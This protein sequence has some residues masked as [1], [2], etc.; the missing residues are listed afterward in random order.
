MGVDWSNLADAD[1]MRA[2]LRRHYGIGGAADVEAGGA[3]AAAAD[4]DD[5]ELA[6]QRELIEM[7]GYDDAMQA[8]GEEG[9]EIQEDTLEWMHSA[10]LA[11]FTGQP[12][13]GPGARPSG[14][15]DGSVEEDR[16][17]A[18]P[19]LDGA[20]VYSGYLSKV[21]QGKF[22]SKRKPKR[23]HFELMQNSLAY[24]D[25][26]GGTR[27]RDVDLTTAVEIRL[28]GPTPGKELAPKSWR[29]KDGCA[30]QLVTPF[31][32]LELHAEEPEQASEWI[33]MVTKQLEAISVSLA[34]EADLDLDDDELVEHAF[35]TF[36]KY[37]TPGADGDEV[38]TKQNVDDMLRE[39]TGFAAQQEYIDTVFNKF[40]KSKSGY[41]DVDE[42][43]GIYKFMF[44]VQ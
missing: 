26:P 44:M 22:Q 38:M 4:E 33:R 19:R 27:L 30:M 43:L 6:E 40:N 11:H 12:I 13:P 16:P 24:Y 31:R 36:E 5:E 3:S 29:A 1:E 7:M 21:A 23:L 15:V 42:F 41:I 9:I 17:K 35:E 32:T 37:A 39:E 25:T 20:V 8:L 28:K 14:G 2:A 18:A 34:E 10:L